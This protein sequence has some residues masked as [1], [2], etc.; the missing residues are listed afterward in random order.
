MLNV[1]RGL[2]V[3]PNP[4]CFVQDPSGLDWYSPRTDQTTGLRSSPSTS[5][6]NRS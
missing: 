2:N 4:P 3:N 5:R 1:G 6:L